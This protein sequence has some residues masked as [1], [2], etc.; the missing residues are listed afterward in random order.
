MSRVL[1]KYR[2]ELKLEIDW[3]SLYTLL[4]KIHFE[5]YVTMLFI[6]DRFFLNSEYIAANI[7]DTILHCFRRFSYEGLTLKHSHLQNIVYLTETCRRFFKVG[8]CAE[9]W[10]EFRSVCCLEAK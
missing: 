1:S 4:L 5:R 9:I 3:R 6:D 10:S 8:S 2:K 7:K